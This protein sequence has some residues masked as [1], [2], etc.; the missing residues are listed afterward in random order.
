MPGG[1]YNPAMADPK[2]PSRI[3]IQT[4]RRWARR[5]ERFPMLTCYDATTAHW[6]WE[7][8][9]KCF[10]VGDTAAQV[11]LGHDS[12]LPVKMPFMI[13]ITAAVRRGAPQSFLMADMPFGSYQCGD[14]EAVRHAIQFLTDGCADAVKLEVGEMHAPLVGRMSEAGVPV[15]AHIGSR[16]QQVR[17]QGGYSAAG[18]TPRRAKAIVRTAE[19]MV[20]HGAAMLLIEAVPGEVSLEIVKSVQA[21]TARTDGPIVP[22]IGC[23]AGP[24][25]HGHV[26]VVHDLL[27]LTTW[28]PPFAKPIADV[29]RQISEAATQWAKMVRSGKYP[30]ND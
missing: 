16:P 25:C 11:I 1:A 5:G 21:I 18:R 22:I 7:G 24:A 27:G 19:A 29:G 13:E 30:E 17:M 12:T 4:L 6:L 23:G 26:V 9:I 8:G 3:T 15:V 28:Q 2:A 20:E 14:D 10:L